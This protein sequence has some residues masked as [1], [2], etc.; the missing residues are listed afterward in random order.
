MKVTSLRRK[1]AAALAAAGMLAPCYATAADLNVNLVMNGDFEEVDTNTVSPPISETN[2]GYNS[3]LILHWS[4]ANAFAYSHQPGVTGVPDYADPQPYGTGY[5]DPPDAGLWYFTSNNAGAPDINAPGLFYQDI[6]VSGG[7]TGTAIAS[8]FASFALSA[9]MSSYNN[10]TDIGR[11]HL[12]FRNSG[13]T[14]LGTALLSDSDFG[15]AN[16]WSLETLSGAVP[17]GTSTIR[18]SLYGTR[19]A[20]GAGPDGYIDNV[21]LSLN[22]FLPALAI[23]VNRTTGEIVLKNQTGSPVNLAGYSITSAFEGLAPNNWLSIADNYDA[24]SPG[25]N[26]FDAAHHWTEVSDPNL[27]TELNEADFQSG[28]GATLAHGQTINLSNLSGAW[29][30]SA[31][32]D[33]VFQYTSNFLT[34]DGIVIYSGNGGSPFAI[35]D[36][37]TDGVINSADWIL[38]RNNQH[39]DLSSDSFAES[40]RLGDLNG[41]KLNNHADFV[42]FKNAYEAA[43]GAGSFLAMVNAVPE[44]ST[45]ILL[46]LAGLF[47]LPLARRRASQR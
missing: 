14:S 34:V 9:W 19:T 23:T 1:L 25:P 40:Y 10:D 2:P 28:M 41:D 27:H 37:N 6:D 20:G 36:I 38:L 45:V 21:E 33:L 46:G 12:D 8:G 35:G 13:G 17:M 30:R 26:Q 42:L 18:L 3:P 29:I 16:V 44:P 32:E 22:D 4:G 24:G 11:A 43:N 7:A 31:T 15:P 39:K 5:G 47:V